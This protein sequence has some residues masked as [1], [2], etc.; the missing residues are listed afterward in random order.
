MERRKVLGM[1]LA[2]PAS[3]ARAAPRARSAGL[4]PSAPRDAFAPN[5]MRASDLIGAAPPPPFSGFN[6]SRA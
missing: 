5:A 2:V 6:A 4:L 3:I 1:D